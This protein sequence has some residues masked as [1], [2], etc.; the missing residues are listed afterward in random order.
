MVYC[1]N[2]KTLVPDNS[3]YC[4]ECGAKVGSPAIMNIPGIGRIS[5]ARFPSFAA[6]AFK[7]KVIVDGTIIGELKEKQRMTVPLLYGTHSLIL[8]I[9][10][11]PSYNTCFVVDENNYNIL[12]WFHI[13]TRTGRPEPIRIRVTDPPKNSITFLQP[14][15]PSKKW[16][17]IKAVLLGATFIAV[18]TYAWLHSGDRATG[19]AT[20]SEPA[21][22]KAVGSLSTMKPIIYSVG[23]MVEYDGLGVKVTEYTFSPFP[24]G[25]EDRGPAEAGF[26]FL[27][28]RADVFDLTDE[29]KTPK[30]ILIKDNSLVYELQILYNNQD[31]Y[32]WSYSRFPESSSES[33]HEAPSELSREIL[34]IY[35]VSQEIQ[36]SSKSLALTMA[37]YASGTKDSVICLLR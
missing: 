18:M 6:K 35:K 3:E 33:K 17:W 19:L 23:E 34:L 26:V 12:C 13:N 1:L 30:E 2:C 15:E 28:I 20:S 14:I 10:L 36:G 16:L 11:A 27:V 24:L 31:K 4:P 9:P 21:V 22:S 8:K 37:S 25:F 5:F 32:D 7:T 29:T